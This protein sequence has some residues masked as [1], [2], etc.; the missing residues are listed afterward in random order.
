[1]TVTMRV[2]AVNFPIPD[3]PTGG[4]P[5]CEVKRLPDAFAPQDALNPDRAGALRTSGA[6]LAGC[7]MPSIQIGAVLASKGYYVLFFEI[8]SLPYH[9]SKEG[10]TQYSLLRWKSPLA[11]IEILINSLVAQGVVDRSKTGLAGLSAGADLV[12]YAATFSTIFHAGE[13][14]TGEVTAPANYFLLDDFRR[15]L[16]FSKSM[17]L[18]LPNS[19][20]I[21]KWSDV[22]ATLNAERATM[23][24]LFQPPD[25]EALAGFWQPSAYVQNRIPTDLYVYPDEGHIKVHPLNRYYV[26]IRNLQWF[27]FWLRDIEDPQP[28]F[29]D[30]MK[31]WE[32]MR[33][34]WD[35]KQSHQNLKPDFT[36]S[37]Q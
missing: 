36:K 19:Q 37:M 21:E 1:V 20:G 31:R 6:A 17:S 32:K 11:G 2:R 25:S 3:E 33:K 23:P 8:S 14:T 15:D 4:L 35:A 34:D 29:A 27:D 30:Q 24:V 7:T 26:M 16:F 5:V 12:D 28:E 22:S 13:A 18:P 9:P 10:N